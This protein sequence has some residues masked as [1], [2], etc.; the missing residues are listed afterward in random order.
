MFVDRQEAMNGQPQRQAARQTERRLAAVL[1]ADVVGY[2]RLIAQDD[3][4]TLKCLRVHRA[5][6]AGRVRQY[7]GRVVDAVGDNLLAEFAS[8]VDAVDC[9]IA[10]QRK[11][12]ARNAGEP[13][14]QRM[15]F[16]IGINVGE[17]V[18]LDGSI[19]G[20]GV[21]IAARVQSL[22]PPG[23]IAIT[24]TVF[25]H[26][27][28][29]LPVELDDQGQMTLKNVPRPVHVLFIHPTAGHSPP[30]SPPE[31]SHRVPGF[32]GRHAIAV[33]PFR[34]LG[35][36][37]EQAYFADGLSEDLINRLSVLRT[38]PVIARDS[39]FVY[40][41]DQRD[42]RELGKLLGA[43]YLVY[44]SVRR[45]GQKIRVSVELVDARDA[46]QL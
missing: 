36:D 40:K 11:L 41:N 19:A 27:E 2:A 33:L 22:A 45:S 44:G 38:Y 35:R 12:N 26:V 8:A 1:S 25:D 46:H 4:T 37:V 7:G 18:A 31:D 24:G 3:L 32:A 17:L 42:A 39:S 34:N 29:R 9:A 14:E 23:G 6:I 20:D 43:R 15:H 13:D 21:N 5:M 30:S 16:R 10:V 28:G